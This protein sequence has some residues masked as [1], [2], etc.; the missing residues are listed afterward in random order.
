MSD[1][2]GGSGASKLGLGPLGAFLYF[3]F[4][5]HIAAARCVLELRVSVGGGCWVGWAGGETRFGFGNSR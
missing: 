5:I 2:S 3:F 1:W 4:S